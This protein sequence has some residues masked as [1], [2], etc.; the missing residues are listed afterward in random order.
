[1]QRSLIVLGCLAAVALVFIMIKKINDNNQKRYDSLVERSGLVETRVD[2]MERKTTEIC[3]AIKNNLN[4]TYSELPVYSLT[5]DSDIH[6]NVKYNT[7]SEEEAKKISGKMQRTKQ[8]ETIINFEV[9]PS[10]VGIK[11][12]DSDEY[13]KMLVELNKSSFIE[14]DDSSESDE[15]DDYD[16]MMEHSIEA[17]KDSVLPSEDDLE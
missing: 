6:E 8:G 2:K 14:N 1:M 13:C 9:D 16:M 5:Y 15:S 17:V 12:N 11:P 10:L 3:R 7:V 4:K